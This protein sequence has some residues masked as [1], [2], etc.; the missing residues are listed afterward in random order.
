MANH[1]SP[2]KA[3]KFLKTLEQDAQLASTLVSLLEQERNTLEQ[4]NFNTY[5]QILADKQQCLVQ[6][7]S[8]AN[9]RR[10]T[11]ESMGVSADS[12][13]FIAFIKLIPSQWQ[14]KF[15]RAWDQLT[16]HL[17]KCSTLNSINGRILIHSQIAADR[18]MRII[19]G[20][21]LTPAFYTRSGRT[22]SRQSNRRLASA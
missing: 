10:S 19:K 17:T 13:G 8:L 7:E 18:L 9:N 12:A 16:A 1:V 3:Q 20:Q 21:D 4:R 6:L 14:N 15:T 2:Q 22:G 5:K 11:M